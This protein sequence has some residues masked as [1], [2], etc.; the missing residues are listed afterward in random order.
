MR[1]PLRLN[2]L[3]ESG[4]VKAPLE[5]PTWVFCATTL[6]DAFTKVLLEVK[7]HFICWFHENTLY[8][9][10]TALRM[11]LWNYP[12]KL[13][14]FESSFA[15]PSLEDEFT[16]HFLIGNYPQMVVSW[17]YSLKWNHPWSVFLWNLPPETPLENYFANP[18]LGGSLLE[19][20]FLKLLLKVKQP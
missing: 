7:P 19:C 2:L 11:A 6:E 20:G 8:S 17:H 15:K 9:E 16:K 12:I 18:P 10:T 13:N 5:T 3:V 1:K 4:F 14:P